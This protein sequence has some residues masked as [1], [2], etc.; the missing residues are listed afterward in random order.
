[1]KKYFGLIFFIFLAA[2]QPSQK[3]IQQAIFQTQTAEVLPTPTIQPTDTL[4]PEPTEIPLKEL[5]LSEIIFMPYDLPAGFIPGQIIRTDIIG[6]SQMKDTSINMHSQNIS[7]ENKQT[8]KTE[9]AGAVSIYIFESASEAKS[10][11]VN[12]YG[13][14]FVKHLGELAYSESDSHMAKPIRPP[15]NNDSPTSMCS[16]TKAMDAQATYTPYCEKFVSFLRCNAIVV[17]SL[18]EDDC[19]GSG[20]INYAYNLDLRLLNLVCE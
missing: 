1:M 6:S 19:S 9:T 5:A 3:A 2:C 4:I 10:V 14:S 13:Y 7:Y 20:L 15:C 12:Q 8:G 17:A 16:L 18:R 11:Y